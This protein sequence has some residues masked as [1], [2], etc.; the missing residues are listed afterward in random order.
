MATDKTT[1]VQAKGGAF[2]R[3]MLGLLV[4]ILAAGAALWIARHAI[5]EQALVALIADPIG[6][7]VDL[8]AEAVGFD[9]AVLA[10]VRV[11]RDHTVVADRVEV[12][13]ALSELLDG[14]LRRATV[15]GLRVQATV[16]PDGVSLGELD[17]V[18]A[19][20]P[21]D[22]AAPAA[23]PPLNLRGA[24]V[25]LATPLGPVAVWADAVTAPG[26]A[27]GLSVKARLGL[28][29]AP[30]QIPGELDLTYAPDGGIRG[31]FVAEPSDLA[32]SPRLSVRGLGG[33]VEFSGGAHAQPP[34]VRARLSAAG[35]E[36]HGIL[37]GTTTGAAT[38]DGTDL[39]GSLKTAAADEKASAEVD[40][41][42]A[43]RAGPLRLS[44]EGKIRAD[45]G[46]DLWQAAALPGDL[47][48][49]GQT[50]AD[51]RLDLSG[52]P[53]AVAGTISVDAASGL[54]KVGPLSA[55]KIS[56]TLQ[57]RLD[58][59]GDRL[60]MQ[61]DGPSTLT[62][63]GLALGTEDGGR[64][65]VDKDLILR[66]GRA[67][68]PVLQAAAAEDGFEVTHDLLVDPVPFSGRLQTEGQRLRLEGRLPRVRL[69]GGLAGAD[70]DGSVELDMGEL[71]VPDWQISL[72]GIGGTLRIAPSPADDVPLAD[73]SVA[74]ISH[75][76]R[77]AAIVPLGLEGRVLRDDGTLRIEATVADR[78]GRLAATLTGRHD[79]ASGAGSAEAR[80]RRLVFGVGIA[81]PEALF[82]VLRGIVDESSGE[83]ALV[84]KA[85]W[86]EG[87]AAGDAELLVENLSAKFG[88]I[89]LRQ[90]N[91]V[92]AFDSRQRKRGPR[93]QEIAVAALDL[94]V[95]LTDGLVKL[96]IDR[97]GR[98]HVDN[99][100]WRVAGGR[101]FAKDFVAD[102]HAA[103]QTI[104]L[105]VADV[106]FGRLVGLAG[107]EGLSVTGIL[108]GKVPVTIVGKDVVIR[109][110][111]LAVREPGRL[112]YAPAAYPGALAAGGEGMA[113]ALKALE[114]FQYDSLSLT[115][116]RQLGGETVVTLHIKGR[117]PD[118]YDG[119]PIALNL[120]VSGRL[121]EILRQ[122]LEGYQ[123]PDQIR[124]RIE[125]FA[126]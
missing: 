21:G 62:L 100:T 121:D 98:V 63:S 28:E 82:P 36:A 49:E 64:V 67:D 70:Y 38:L 19:G 27:G 81:G 23:L 76:V 66:L 95:P 3:F 108:D 91:G 119:Y 24:R 109:D 86:G 33:D 93:A 16:G 83:L 8:R 71:D 15:D 1:E 7:H 13:Y 77:P 58:G 60:A 72:A 2:R 41:T 89:S 12:A 54:T 55:A 75:R 11:G 116:N 30:G 120:N 44:L 96:R 73:I 14:R 97:K 118:L 79:L 105:E 69:A 104:L 61:L 17:P 85:A 123:I 43:P 112:S 68:A 37:L 22:A 52:T 51:F 4:A 122:Q 45:P 10:D 87:S 80:L 88:G 25:D 126:R 106:D 115:L 111:R 59:G 40:V 92:L 125:Q 9:R 113:L 90:L 20:G 114:N 117:N 57:G 99:M 48:I 65:T 34:K 103:R 42:F 53:D 110:G 46:A 124:K 50:M 39:R 107:L 74:E 47:R 32:F 31:R 78:S 5:L 94:G 18:L 29:A 6:L 26:E 101:V 102:P 84:G 35:A 56:A